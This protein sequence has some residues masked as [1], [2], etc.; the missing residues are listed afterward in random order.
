MMDV[1]I[2][3]VPCSQTLGYEVGCRVIDFRNIARCSVQ[4]LCTERE[5]T[6]TV[7]DSEALKISDAV[8]LE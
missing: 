1:Y 5:L 7:S 2:K 4:R 3:L 6:A 8:F